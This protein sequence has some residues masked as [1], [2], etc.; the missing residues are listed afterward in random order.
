VIERTLWGGP[1]EPFVSPVV[2]AQIV[3]EPWQLRAYFALRHAIFVEEQ[4][5][6]EMSDIDEH[7]RIATPIVVQGHAAGIPDEV[8]GAVRIYPASGGTWFG[9]RL[10]V[11]RLYRSRGM[12]GTALI[13]SAVSTAHARGCTRFLATIQEGNV[14][15][16]ER[17]H[18]F[19]IRPLDVCGRPHRLMEAN[20]AAYPP[21]VAHPSQPVDGA[22][23]IAELRRRRAA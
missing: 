14:G 11:C 9:G 6:F 15:Y 19:G 10:G 12:V 18:F 3:S 1:V 20:L 7:D 8:I 13:F 5:M 17:H 16:F 4:R 23:A 2:T 21:R 22:Y